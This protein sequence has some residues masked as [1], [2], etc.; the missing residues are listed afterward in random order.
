MFKLQDSVE[1]SVLAL[2][3]GVETLYW[4]NGY[5]AVW[6]LLLVEYYLL[7]FQIVCY[8][9]L[10]QFLIGIVNTKLFQVVFRKGFKTV[11]IQQT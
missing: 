2:S 6:H 3:P 7:C 4:V 10:L 8:E 1:F 9:V 11:N 5:D